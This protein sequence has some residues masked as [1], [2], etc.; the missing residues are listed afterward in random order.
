MQKFKCEIAATAASLLLAILAMPQAAADSGESPAERGRYIAI[1]GN[2]I[3]CH[4]SEGGEP[5]AGGLAF[6]TP[7][8][9][10]YSTNITPD[11]DTGIGNWTQDQFARAV[12]EGVRADGAHLYPAFPYT[13]YTKLTDEDVAALYDYFKTLKPVNAAARPNEMGF[14]Y[15]QRWALG[16]WKMMFFDAGRFAPDASKSQ[17][18]NRGAYL[19]E[20][21]GHCSACHAPRNMLGAEKS[22]MTGGEI[23]A[24]VATGETRTW[25]AP[26]L[27]DVSNGLQSW[28]LDDVASYLK[29]GR[30][31]LAET[32][33]PMNEVILNS[34]RHLTDADVRAMATYLKSL[35][36]DKGSVGKVASADVLKEGERLYNLNC[37][38]C[39]QPNG[40]GDIDYDGGAKLVHNPLVQASNPA[41]LI[42]VILYGPQVTD[43][44][45]KQWKDMPSF[46]EKLADE[47]IAAIASYMRNAWG[48][49]GGAVTEEQV[50]AQR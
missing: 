22:A 21:L 42:N 14:P 49:V 26:N 43:L 30:N 4:T 46:H 27:T 34:T 15:N 10:I 38:T 45:E 12:R 23:M 24:V 9:K 16:A 1:A 29:K 35:P 6:E 7:F 47:D 41:S 8:G 25:S 40:M 17:E 33:G 39:H 11:P 3:S 31:P 20:S 37:G 13:A 36:G 19:V 32:H 5:F 18:W 44:G 50:S 48:N 28:S 2:C